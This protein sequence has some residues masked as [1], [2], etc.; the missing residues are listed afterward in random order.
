MAN[1]TTR[2]EAMLVLAPW[3]CSLSRHR[4]ALIGAAERSA[5]CPLAASMQ[6]GSVAVPGYCYPKR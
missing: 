2:R 3:R 1:Q 4:A 5:L 6:A